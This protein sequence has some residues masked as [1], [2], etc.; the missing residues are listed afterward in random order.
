[1][2]GNKAIVLIDK[3]DPVSWRLE[4]RDVPEA[5]PGTIVIQV[6][7]SHLVRYSKE[8]ISGQPYLN[9]PTPAVLGGNGIGRIHSIG[10]D[11]TSFQPGDLVLV[12]P[13]ITARD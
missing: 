8:H 9:W 3:T 6:L 11:T 1:M 2:P 12:E 13:T 4:D 7:Y 10:V 5:G